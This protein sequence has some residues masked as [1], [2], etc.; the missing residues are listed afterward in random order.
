M[1]QAFEWYVPDDQKKRWQQLHDQLP[2]LKATGIDN[3]WKPP[4]RGGCKAS[5]P[6]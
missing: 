1:M 3:I 2:Q 4:P 5:S 6:G